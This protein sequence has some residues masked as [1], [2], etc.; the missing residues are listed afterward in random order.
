M[1]TGIK[2]LIPEIRLVAQEIGLEDAGAQVEV[3]QATVKTGRKRGAH[4]NVAS[5]RPTG[6]IIPGGERIG[7]PAAEGGSVCRQ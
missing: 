2:K 1:E 4:A 3:V 6:P 5:G 7:L